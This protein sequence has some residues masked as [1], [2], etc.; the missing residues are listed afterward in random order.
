VQL[1]LGG[2]G[3]PSRICGTWTVR[4]FEFGQ[5]L[6]EEPGEGQTVV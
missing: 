1:Q 3:R 4:A 2:I 6:G 5:C